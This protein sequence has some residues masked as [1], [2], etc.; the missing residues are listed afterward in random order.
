[1]NKIF[2]AVCLVLI[3]VGSAQAKNC[4]VPLIRT[5][6]NQTVTGYMTVKSGKRCNIRMQFSRGP[7]HGARIV[8]RPSHGGVHVNGG[9]DIIYQSRPGYIGAD[10]FT[11]ARSGFDTR[12]LRVTRTVRVEV[13]VTP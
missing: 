10:S 4:S 8:A 12:N 2:V 6:N 3:M 7:T 13:T 1:M 11:Y 9:N 5:L